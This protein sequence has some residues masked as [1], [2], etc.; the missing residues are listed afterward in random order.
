VQAGAEVNAVTSVNGQVL[1]VN[2]DQDDIPNGS[3]WVRTA[4]DFTN[5]AV[6]EL[7]AASNH[8]TDFNNPHNTTAAL[9]GL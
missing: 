1:A 7:N 2:L 5:T 9:V 4:N 6:S 3:T 8:L